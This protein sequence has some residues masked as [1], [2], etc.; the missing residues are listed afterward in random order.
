MRGM[1]GSGGFGEAAEASVSIGG[2][3]PDRSLAKMVS[4]LL[5]MATTNSSASTTNTEG[6]TNTATPG[7]ESCP[8]LENS[9]CSGA[10]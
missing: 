6:M 3:E 9:M 7:A 1:G 5:F 8:I 2:V 10:S 4:V